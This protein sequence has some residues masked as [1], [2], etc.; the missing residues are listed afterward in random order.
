[1]IILSTAPTVNSEGATPSILIS[2]ESDKLLPTSIVVTSISFPA[3]S[4]KTPSVDVIVTTD[5][6]A[7]A[8][9]TKV[10]LPVCTTYCARSFPSKTKL[11]LSYQLFHE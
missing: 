4:L 7:S 6:N 11:D 2:F 9:S 8:P 10:E 3:R 1:M 5:N